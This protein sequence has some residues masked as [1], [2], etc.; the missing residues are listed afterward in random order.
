[1]AVGD[2]RAHAARLGEGQ[3]L[4]IVGLAAVGVEPVGMGRDVAEQMQ[5]MGCEPGVIR[6]ELD[7]AIAQAPRL[8]EPA[9]QQTSATQRVVGPGGMADNSPRRLP[10]HELLAAARSPRP[11]PRSA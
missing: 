1:M 9:E 4:A 5:R 7:S 3:R 10:L 8:V 6:R 2:E 11:G